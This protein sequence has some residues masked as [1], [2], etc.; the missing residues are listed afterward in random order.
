MALAVVSAQDGCENT[1]IVTITRNLRTVGKSTMLKTKLSSAARGLFEDY[2]CYFVLQLHHEWLKKKKKK[3][4]MLRRN[5]QSWRKWTAN[6]F[7]GLS[8][9]SVWLLLVL[10][11]Q[12][13]CTAPVGQAFHPLALFLLSQL[14]SAITS[15]V[16]GQCDSVHI[17]LVSVSPWSAEGLSRHAGKLEKE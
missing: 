9:R 1:L 17:P 8:V 11:A 6:C 15:G 5:K 4:D 14:V 7:R 3:P 12:R 16:R 13:L 10:W 2:S